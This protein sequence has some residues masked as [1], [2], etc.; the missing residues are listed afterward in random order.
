[1]SQNSSILKSRSQIVIFLVTALS[2][3]GL[4]AFL[5]MPR[6][7]DP[8]IKRRNAITTVVLPGA[9]P[10]KLLR[11]VVRPIEDKLLAVQELKKV[12]VEI[13]PDVAVFQLELR[14]GV[15]DIADAWREVERA[16]DRAAPGLPNQLPAP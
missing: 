8:R 16:L 13:R 15:R 14:D 9:A 4:V 3:L 5:A 2:L 6:E 12:E 10:E 7:E 1:M 11:T